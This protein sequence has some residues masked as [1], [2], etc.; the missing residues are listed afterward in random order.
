M[1]KV[2]PIR[3]DYLDGVR[4]V[5]ALVVVF[6]HFKNAFF[7]E[8]ENGTLSTNFWKQFDL[9]FLTGGFSVQ[10]FFVL[11]GFV[12]AYNSFA[13]K[14]FLRKQFFKRGYRLFAPVFISSLLYYFFAQNNLFYFRQLA[15]HHT[16]PWIAEHWTGGIT[17]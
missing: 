17:Y 7:Y 4:G 15:A 11:S 3:F 12:L 8:P 9:F 13:R 6:G 10:L 16:S 2:K 14:S 5:A 1:N